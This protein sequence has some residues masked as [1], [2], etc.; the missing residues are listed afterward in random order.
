[1]EMESECHLQMALSEKLVS[2]EAKTVTPQGQELS[3]ASEAAQ[4]STAGPSSTGSSAGAVM[5][6]KAKSGDSTPKVKVKNRVLKHRHSDRV[7]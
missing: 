3:L 7:A 6:L 2:R 4:S 5:A 1:M